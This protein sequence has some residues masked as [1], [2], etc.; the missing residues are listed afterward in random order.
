VFLKRCSRRKC[1]KDH[2]YWQLVESHRTPRGSRH[3]V[4]AY[5]GELLKSE[6]LGWA[7]LAATLDGKAA[8]KARQTSLFEPPCDPGGDP[9]PDTVQVKTKDVRVEGA[10]D[11]GDV[12]LALTLWRMLG[13]DDLF[14]HELPEGRE[15]IPWHLMACILGVARFVEPSSEVHVQD[16]WYPRTALPELLGVPVDKVEEHRL[17]RV[18]DRALPLKPKIE[19]ALK[20]RIGELFSP[21]FDILLY[22]VTS[23]YFEG[24]AKGNP[25]AKRGHSRDHRGDCKQVCIG[26]VVTTDGFPLGHEVFAGNRND[27]RTL[28]EVVAAMEAKYGKAK[29]IWVFDRGIASEANLEFLRERGGQ[30]LVGTPKSQLRK[31]EKELIDKDWREVREGID[32]KLV[33]SPG[34]EET[35]VL[36]RSRD[37]RAKEKA[38]HDRFASRITE[39]LVAIR[40]GLRRAK[41]PRDKSKLERRIGRLLGK[42][43]RAAKAFTI[44]LLED[45]DRPAGLKL[46]YRSVRKWTDWAALSEG[47]YLLRTNI[48]GKSPEYLWRTYIQLTDVEEVF[49]TEKS[50]LAIRPIWHQMEERVQAHVLFSFLA[51]AMW[52]TL[53]TWMERSGLGRGVRTVIEEFARIKATDVVLPTTAGRDVKLTCITRPDKA[54]RAII[55]RLGLEL[56]E[57]LGR[58]RW[59]PI[60]TE[61]TM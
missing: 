47:C 23:T 34:G 1:G 26:L 54:Q 5:L 28:K 16:V 50:E 45:T 58:P 57:R 53:Q 9:V 36:C 27:A 12:F 25:Q 20:K 42:N 6:R 39:G 30:Y 59:V 2:V 60:P 14:E 22:D 17:Y 49:R 44:E 19:L 48:G 43:T 13:L 37:R 33:P 38:M 32:V 29:R 31:F 46:R 40:K 35:F 24:E 8:S 21:D 4:V 51:Y 15:T 10:R 55:D 41:K 56:P 11:F 61:A 3:R 7:R 52:K 18:L